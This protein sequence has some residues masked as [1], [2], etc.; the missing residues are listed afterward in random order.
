MRSGVPFETFTSQWKELKPSEQETIRELVRIGDLRHQILPELERGD[1]VKTAL[2]NSSGIGGSS[3]TVEW[4]SR[5]FVTPNALFI[6][7]H[8]G[9]VL[10]DDKLDM[11]SLDPDLW[12]SAYARVRS[13][14]D[15][16]SDE[17]AFVRRAFEGFF[18]RGNLAFTDGM[19]IPAAEL[20]YLE[21]R[22]SVWGGGNVANGFDVGM[23]TVPGYN[24]RKLFETA[25]SVR[26]DEGRRTRALFRKMTSKL[27][28]GLAGI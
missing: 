26:R 17:T 27:A 3:A 15:V 19:G 28:P 1:F 4:M 11:P 18:D 13:G 10:R 25:F 7:G 5:E 8:G 22:M 12:A 14:T 21:H 23:Y 2:Q 24:S 6:I 9:E 16:S 20:Y